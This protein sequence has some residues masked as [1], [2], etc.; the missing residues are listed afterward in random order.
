V[1]L[2]REYMHHRPG[3]R[4]GS[5]CYWV[6]IYEGE[7][8]DAPVVVC[9]PS[10]DIGSTDNTT[11]EALGYVA[12]EVVREFF[13]DGLPDLPRPLLWTEHR[14]GR[15]RRG[16]GRY[17]L[18]GFA[19]YRPRPEGLGFVKRVSLGAS[20]REPLSA[21]EVANLTGERARPNP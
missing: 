12:A 5:R 6:R 18:I 9:S 2:A 3:Y 15:R 19:T 13:A 16:P 8:G 10:T 4:F 20:E 1:K 7:S 17:S 11:T 14:P 21:E